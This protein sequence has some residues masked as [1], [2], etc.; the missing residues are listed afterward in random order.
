MY[1][2]GDA[3]YICIRQFDCFIY[4]SLNVETRGD[5]MH[6]VYFSRF[7]AACP[8]VNPVYDVQRWFNMDAGD[9]PCVCGG[10]LGK[11]SPGMAGEV[12]S[13]AAGWQVST[14]NRFHSEW[15]DTR[16][17]WVNTRFTR[18]GRLA[19]ADRHLRVTVTI[20]ISRDPLGR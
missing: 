11:A 15:A 1:V 8:R 4:E 18:V 7:A 13:G 3:D 6:S 20:T 19:V 12:P 16:L 9:K 10:L 14:G 2:Y 17:K 5:H